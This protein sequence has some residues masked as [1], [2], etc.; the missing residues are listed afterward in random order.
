MNGMMWKKR[1]PIGQLLC[2]TGCANFVAERI[3][4]NRNPKEIILMK[5]SVSLLRGSSLFHQL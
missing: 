5:N 4:S 3:A 2:V 1:T